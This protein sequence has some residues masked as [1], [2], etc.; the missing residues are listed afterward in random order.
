MS[1][2][3]EEVSTEEIEEIIQKLEQVENDQE[4]NKENQAPTSEQ[5]QFK[6]KVSETKVDLKA[7]LIKRIPNEQIAKAKEMAREELMNMLAD[8]V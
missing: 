3:T 8:K 6:E 5:I 2:P 4:E 1:K 7:E